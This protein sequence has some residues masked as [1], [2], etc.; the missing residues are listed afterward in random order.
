MSW[1]IEHA[2]PLQ[3]L[4]Q[5]PGGWAQTCITTPPAIQLRDDRVCES[6]LGYLL[7]VLGQVHRVLRPD[8][9]LWLNLR[10]SDR[11]RTPASILPPRAGDVGRPSDPAPAGAHAGGTVALALQADG[12]TQLHPACAGR[13]RLVGWGRGE[14]LVFAKEPRFFYNPR[15]R[16]RAAAWLR[17]PGAASTFSDRRGERAQHQS[18]PSPPGMRRGW[19]AVSDHVPA[20]EAERAIQRCILASSTPAAC[21][22]CGAP[23]ARSSRRGGLERWRA[24]CRHVDEGAR[25]LVIDP[26]AGHADIGLAARRLGRSYLGIEADQASA[27]VARRRLAASTPEPV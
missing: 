20:W 8:G 11:A 18:R 23:W 12:W 4:S 24:G 7:A 16:P 15:A 3:L 9:T 13:A 1:R 27:T 25:S 10:S 21:G 19:C 22:I 6:S 14:L 26:Y 5:L 2:Y 17:F